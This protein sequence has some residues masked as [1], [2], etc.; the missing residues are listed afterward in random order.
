MKKKIIQYW[1]EILAY[2]VSFMSVLVTFYL[3]YQNSAGAYF[4]AGGALII[5]AGVLLASSRKVEQFQEKF[6]DKVEPVSEQVILSIAKSRGVAKKKVPRLRELIQKESDKGVE[7]FLN[8]YKFEFKKHEIRL[9]VIGTLLN[10]F[11]DLLW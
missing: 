6:K 8:Q 7:R 11:G 5:V 2:S 3:K 4:A 9:V 1:R 10:G